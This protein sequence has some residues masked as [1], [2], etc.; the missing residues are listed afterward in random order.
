[1]K[2]DLA[3]VLHPVA[4]KP[5][6][7]WVLDTVATVGCDET[8]VVVGHQAGAVRRLLPAGVRSVIQE[9][10][11]GTGH[12][13][14]VGLEALDCHPEDTIVVM[15]GDMPLVKGMTLRRLL[16]RH[17]EARAA[18]TLLSVVRDDPGAYGRILRRAG[19]VV[20]IVEARDASPEQLQIREVNTSVYAFAA[21]ALQATIGEIGSDNAPGEY[22]LTDVVGLLAAAGCVIQAM[23]TDPVEGVGVNSVEELQQ[24]DAILRTR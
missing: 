14:S 11:L 23:T 24:V 3:K 18:A 12:A 20:G 17:L 4:G 7:L 9:P 8:V 19:V 6:L 1:M 5:L 13:A 2:S 21:A 15:P 16:D 10:Q 22:Y